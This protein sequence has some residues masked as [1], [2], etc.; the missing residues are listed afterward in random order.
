MQPWAGGTGLE[1][2]ASGAQPQDHSKYKSSS[3]LS[4]PC[5]D[6]LPTAVNIVASVN[7]VDM[8]TGHGIINFNSVPEGELAIRAAVFHVFGCGDV[9]F[10]IPP[11]SLPAAPY[12][13]YP[14]AAT[15]VT[16]H[17]T[18]TA[19]TEARLWFSFRG[20]VGSAGMGAPNGSVTIH[21][22]TT[23][24]D[25]TFDLHA[26][27]IQ[28]KKVAALLTLDQ[29]EWPAQRASPSSTKRRSTSSRWS[30]QTT[31]SAWSASTRTPILQPIP[32]GRD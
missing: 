11:V 3:I 14:P 7:P 28:R 19:W 20:I 12:A 22:S 29:S 17:H 27:T 4:P 31:A 26:D 5:Y 2:W 10:E 23:G 13:V 21:C 1:P 6:T 15:S 32:H 18:L 25:F 9:T 8:M 24:D 16:V 30:R